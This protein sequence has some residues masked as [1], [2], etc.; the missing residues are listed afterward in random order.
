MN[1]ND[2]MFALSEREQLSNLLKST[3]RKLF[4]KQKKLRNSSKESRE[5]YLRSKPVRT[6]ANQCS[7]YIQR[8]YSNGDSWY[9]CIIRYKSTLIFQ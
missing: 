2:Y 3:P 4:H 6:R 1:R 5:Y 9:F 7:T 8:S